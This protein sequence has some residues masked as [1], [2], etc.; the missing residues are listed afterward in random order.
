M[1]VLDIIRERFSVRRYTPAPVSEEDLDTVLEA[2]RL[3]QSA[4]NLQEWRLIVV[5]E[6][7]SRRGLAEAAKGQMFVAEAPTV[8][9][10]CAEETGYVMTN[11]QQ[12]YPI[13]LAIAMENMVLAAWERGLGSCWLGAF[14]EDRVKDL[15]GIPEENVRVVGL[16][17]LGHPEGTAPAKNRLPRE[18]MVRYERW[19]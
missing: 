7:S 3:S 19:S 9:V 13:D 16:L 8:I 4:R 14:F 18:R 17:T 11:G 5:R 12:S 2:A 15:L 6:E 10:C 1:S